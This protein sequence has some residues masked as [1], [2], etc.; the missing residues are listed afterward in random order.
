MTGISLPAPTGPDVARAATQVAL[1]L[2]VRGET[3]GIEKGDFARLDLVQRVVAPDEQ[4]TEAVVV[5]DGDCLDGFREWQA[6]Q[7]GHVLA[8]RLAGCSDFFHLLGMAVPRLGGGNCLGQFHVGGVAGIGAEGN[9]V[10]AGVRQ[11]VEFM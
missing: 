11:H 7:F 8:A 1:D 2:L 3:E 10:L 9:R 5:H 6:Q 4:Q